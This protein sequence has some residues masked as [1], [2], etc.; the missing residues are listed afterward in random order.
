MYNKQINKAHKAIKLLAMYMSDPSKK[1]NIK[2]QIETLRASND[3]NPTVSL[4]SAIFCIYDENIK[5]AVVHLS[6]ESTMEQ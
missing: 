1:E 2:T 4:I 5:E 3:K 6:Q